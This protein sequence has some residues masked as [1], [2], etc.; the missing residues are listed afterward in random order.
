[1]LTVAD[2]YTRECH[3]IHVAR[4]IRAGSVM[5]NNAVQAGGCI[6]LPFGGEG[7]SGVGRSQGEMGYFNYVAP[8]SVMTSPDSAANLWM[9]YHEGALDMVQ[10]MMRMVRLGTLHRNLINRY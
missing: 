10:G 3:L 7:E 6:T 5:V 4:R 1:M 9:P 2:E 8:Q